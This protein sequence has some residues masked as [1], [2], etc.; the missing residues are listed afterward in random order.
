MAVWNLQAVP[1]LLEHSL[2]L[3]LERLMGRKLKVASERF[4]REKLVSIVLG[5]PPT[6][7]NPITIQQLEALRA[8]RDDVQLGIGDT[9]TRASRDVIVVDPTGNASG[10]LTLVDGRLQIKNPDEKTLEWMLK[11]SRALNGRVVDST[12]RTYGS[13]RETYVHPD[14]VGARQSLARNVRLARNKWVPY[15]QSL[16]KWMVMGLFVLLGATLFVVFHR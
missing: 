1:F 16:I 8:T 11:L 5:T 4:Y 6:H 12:L 14:D 7:R 10:V 3:A 2:V 15:T 13:P 9:G